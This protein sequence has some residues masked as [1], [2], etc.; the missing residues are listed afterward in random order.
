MRR[1]NLV[2]EFKDGTIRYR[3]PFAETEAWFTPG[4]RRRPFHTLDKAPGAI[5]S[6]AQPQNYCAFCPANYVQT[7]PEKSRFEKNGRD[8]RLCDQPSPE[9]VFANQAR[10]RRIGN[11]YEIISYDY[12]QKKYGFDLSEKEQAH[13]DAYLD[14]EKGRDHLFSLLNDKQKVLGQTPARPGDVDQLLRLSKPFFGGSHE[15]IIPQSHFVD[16]ATDTTQLCSTGE[17]SP[18]EHFYYFALSIHAMNDIYQNNSFVRYVCVYTNWLRD[19]GASFEHLHRQVI[20]I[21]LF[22]PETI[23]GA[24]LARKNPQVYEDYARFLAYDQDLILCDNPFALAAV[25]IGRPYPAVIIFSKSKNLNPAE[26]SPEEVRGMSDIVHA[27]HAAFGVDS[28]VNEEWYYS[29]PDS[30]M[31]LPWYVVVKWRNHRLAGIEGITQIFPNEVSPLD[32]KEMLLNKLDNLRKNG[33]IAEM[34]IGGECEKKSV[35][36]YWR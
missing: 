5:L 4:R 25:D 26:H 21:D 36:E 1:W 19:A 15:L 24:D 13:Q 6:E 32:V 10:F 33:R 22:S 3:N 30:G 31:R 27:V 28:A 18:E 2:E 17:L 23:H 34:N 8:W 11:L 16:G 29:P 14:S 35:L 20:G 9:R 12:W 7:T